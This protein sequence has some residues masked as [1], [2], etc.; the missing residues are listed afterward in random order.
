MK[1]VSELRQE[2]LQVFVKHTRYYN[3]KIGDKT[4]VVG[5]FTRAQAAS[6]GYDGSDIH[7]K[8][9]ATEVDIFKD[10]VLVAHGGTICSLKDSF[11]RR[12]GL[13][14][15]LARALKGLDMIN[16]TEVVNEVGVDRLRSF[17]DGKLTRREFEASGTSARRIIRAFGIDETRTRARKALARRS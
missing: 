12:L 17:C 14:I 2:G 3:I 13:T 10:G 15:A 6:Y 1:T 5:P 9:G 16:W 4:Y 7:A 11:V 8:G